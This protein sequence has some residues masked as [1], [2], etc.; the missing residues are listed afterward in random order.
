M[1]S[2]IRDG[3]WASRSHSSTRCTR[4]EPFLALSTVLAALTGMLS[5]AQSASEKRLY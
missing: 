4:P 3:P 1:L 5:G 2:R